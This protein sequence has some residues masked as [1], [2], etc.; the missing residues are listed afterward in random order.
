MGK[1]THLILT[2][3]RISKFGFCL[4]ETFRSGTNHDS[5]FTTYETMVQIR[6]FSIIAHIDHGK[7]TL[8]DRLIQH[9]R[10]I[11]EREFRDQILDTMDIERERGITIKSQTVTLPYTN[12]KGEEFELNLIDTP[13]HVDFSYEV[14]RA[15]ASSEG[16]LLLVDAAQ[17][18]EAQTIANLYAAMDHNLEI[19]P[20]I[21][22]IDLPAADIERI[23]EEIEIELGLDS[24]TALLC[25]AKE[26]IGIEEV[27]EA[28]TERIPAPKGSTSKPL[29]ALIFD[30]QY[31]SFRGTVVSC[32]VFDGIIRLGDTIRFMSN[33]AAYKVEEVGIFKLKLDRRA[34]LTAGEVGYL[35]AGIKTVSDTRVG[36]TITLDSNPSP[37]PLP[38]FKE[39]KPM[40]FSSVY[41][42][43]SDD[44]QPLIDAMEKYK[45]ND[46]A[47]IY[48]KDSS[49][50]LG[51]G[52]RCGFLGLLHLEIVQE[53]LERE[54]GQSIIMTAPSVRYKFLLKSG[55]YITVD[56]P[57]YYP[58]PG[59]I[60]KAE[61]PFVRISIIIPERYMGVVMKLCTE[62]RG[63]NSKFHYP[64]TGRIEINFD[65]PLAEIIYDFYDRLKTITQGYGSFDYEFLEHREGELVKVDMMVNREKVDALSLIVHRYNARPRALHIC[66]RLKKE[67]PRQMFKIIIQAAIGGTIIARSTI[68]PFRKDVTAK[69]Y[70]GD[71]TRKRKLLE[72]QKK[73]KQR[74]KMVGA[75]E[76]PQ[77]AF[78]SILKTDNT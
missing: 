2:E 60:E 53:R 56:N 46:A 66:E 45:L 77:K 32:R 74:M 72:K 76:I 1:D 19:I 64:V 42:V 16:V 9:V 29:S 47:L 69:C 62:R 51:Q 48:Q 54:F 71:I 41:P 55:E 35:I 57:Q 4:N 5:L 10:L 11:D 33:E 61:E 28:I 24:D 25:S 36:D 78:V 30:A 14:S 8:A 43:A 44:Y 27:F 15:L 65:M 58:D 40:V 38:G 34:E 63:V 31:D 3:F 17:G 52:F 22:K 68:N 59:T 13:G 26:A 12:K 18:V 20:V 49:A 50:A 75:V 7:S 70:G 73:G 6:N 39:A 37:A 23:K 21:N 67:I